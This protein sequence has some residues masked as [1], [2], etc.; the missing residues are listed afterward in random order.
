MIRSWS[1]AMRRYS[2]E[3]VTRNYVKSCRSLSFAINF[4]NKN[5][6]QLLNAAIIAPKK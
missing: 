5:L 6:K 4:T 2:I 3:P 1:L